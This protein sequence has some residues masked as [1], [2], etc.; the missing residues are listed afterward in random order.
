MAFAL[1]FLS[2]YTDGS[3]QG[4]EY[5]TR[6]EAA[7]VICRLMDMQNG[8]LETPAP[9]EQVPG[10]YCTDSKNNPC[11]ECEYQIANAEC[12]LTYSHS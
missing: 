1:K 11:D 4:S 10:T 12:I 5:M 3:F 8:T 2:G 7:V 6:G 9:E